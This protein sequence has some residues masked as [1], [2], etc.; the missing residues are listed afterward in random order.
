MRRPGIEPGPK[1]FCVSKNTK[2]ILLRWQRPI[3]PF[4]HRRGWKLFRAI[5]FREMALGGGYQMTKIICT[6]FNH[7]RVEISGPSRTRT[8]D[9]FRVRES[10]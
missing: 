6:L 2:G 1:R 10:S 7:R 3:V 5:E 9:R 8:G 4:N